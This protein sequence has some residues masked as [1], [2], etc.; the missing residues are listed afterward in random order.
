MNIHHYTVNPKKCKSTDSR[1]CLIETQ[2]MSLSRV[3]QLPLAAD[4]EQTARFVLDL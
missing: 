3:N 2:K 1:P 4:K